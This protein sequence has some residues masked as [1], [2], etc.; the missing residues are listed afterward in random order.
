MPDVTRIAL[1]FALAAQTLA[2]QVPAATAAPVPPAVKAPG[3]PLLSYPQ[4]KDFAVADVDGE[5]Y[6]LERLAQYIERRHAPGFRTFLASSQGQ[7]LLRSDLMAPWVRHYADVVA[8]IA[9]AVARKLDA[10]TAEPVLSQ[11]LTRTFDNYL[12]DYQK[13]RQSGRKPD[14][15]A[16]PLT[17]VQVANLRAD[18]QM[19][20]GLDS[21]V[22]GWLDFM[23]PANYTE[24]QL[25]EFFTENARVFGGMVT[26]AHILVRNRDDGTGLLLDAEGQKQALVRIAEIKAR[27]LADGS[28]FREVARLRSEDLR[29]AKDGGLLNNVTRFDRRL[30]AALCR[31]AWFLKDG[32]VSDVVETPYGYHLVQ[33]IGF[34]QQKFMLFTPDMQPLVRETMQVSQQED[35]LFS[36]RKTHHVVLHL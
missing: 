4:D 1:A 8:L 14:V 28:N 16:P 35:L 17:A 36:V 2:A 31:T 3:H 32:E 29:T 12:A 22:Q 34:S 15:P 13:Q 6:T 18:F 26:F 27:L 25:R 21:E 30:P 11:A 5:A 19:R 9:E 24:A 10:E 23:A 33:R 7:L 20:Y